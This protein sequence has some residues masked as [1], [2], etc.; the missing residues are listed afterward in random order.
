MRVKAVV[1]FGGQYA[2]SK[3]KEADLPK[4]PVTKALIEGGFIQRVQEV[5]KPAEPEVPAEKPAKPDL[6]KLRK[7]DLLKICEEKGIEADKKAKKEDLIAAI[8]AQE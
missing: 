2:M 6:Q 8:E 1:D 5:E 4:N 7:E 3:G